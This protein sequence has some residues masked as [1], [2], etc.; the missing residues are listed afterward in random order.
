MPLMLK[1]GRPPVST[2][3]NRSPM[4]PLVA[5]AIGEACARARMLRPQEGQQ[6]KFFTSPADIVIYGGAAGGGKSFALLLESLRHIRVPRFGSVIFRRTY[7][8]IFNKGGLWDTSGEIFNGTGCT[9]R[10]SDAMWVWPNDVTCKFSHMQHESNMYDWQGSQIPLIGW[11][12]LT[13]FSENMFF[14]LLSRSRS[15]CGVTPYVRATCNPDPDSWVAK[16]L[17]WWI[18]Q[19]TGFPL[20]ERDGAIRWF[21]RLDGK[22]HWE[23]DPSKLPIQATPDGDTIPP[24][25]VTFIK[26]SVY[27]NKIL[28]KANPDYLG[29][30]MA[31]PSIERARLL[32]GNWKIRRIAGSYFKRH[33]VKMID[34][35]P[36]GAMRSTRGWDKASTEVSDS[37]PD[38]DWTVGV[39]II[40][41]PNGRFLVADVRRDRMRPI[42][43][44]QMLLHTAMQDGI[45][46][47]IVIEQD[48]GSAGVFELNA[49]VTLL[50]G[51]Q[52]A[53][54][55][56]TDAKHVRWLPLSA[57][58][59]A[60]NVDVLR[61]PW[62]DDFFS[63]LESLGPDPKMY[64]HDDQAD[65]ASTA[66]NDLAMSA[67]MPGAYVA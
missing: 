64:G 50:A 4:H 45:A 3:P 55:R 31:L 65:A 1:R 51:Y 34:V 49:F 27:D 11:D 61:A 42:G 24:K 6:E 48:P 9:A 28:L 66:F 13:H 7:S 53:A 18:D 29:N 25:S 16:F 14:Y 19:E 43:V 37:S 40:R 39:K 47:K 15:T 38:P 20:P 21:V 60:G 58:W 59:E 46:T 5:Q 62:N 10:E 67:V 56:V 23:S 2:R 22:L 63:E 26:A 30:L 8:E 41:Y 17:S 33:L 32:D 57:Q 54:N 44:Q 12:E 35:M 52:V 36:Q